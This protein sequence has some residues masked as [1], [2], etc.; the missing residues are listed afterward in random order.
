MKIKKL[1]IVR[2]IDER[3]FPDYERQGYSKLDASEKPLKTK[4]EKAT[5]KIA[6]N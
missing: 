6:D 2:E 1:N 4:S 3:L 5:D